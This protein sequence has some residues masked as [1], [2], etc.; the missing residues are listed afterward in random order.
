[1]AGTIKV[2]TDALSDL[3][4][5]VKTIKN[6]LDDQKALV[7]SLSS[8]LDTAITGTAP[9]IK[10]FDLQ[11]DLWAKL[12]NDLTVDMDNAYATLQKVLLDAESAIQT[13]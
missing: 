1:M 11:F 5:F 2:D 13:L 12:L 8:R 9:S 4:A 6:A 7:P 10:K 3:V